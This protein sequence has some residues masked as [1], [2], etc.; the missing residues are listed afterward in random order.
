MSVSLSCCVCVR[1][2]PQI[3]IFMQSLEIFYKHKHPK[4]LNHEDSAA[5]LEVVLTSKLPNNSPDG[6]C[7]LGPSF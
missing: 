4:T 3:Y 7:N 5:I 1:F 2:Y 6:S